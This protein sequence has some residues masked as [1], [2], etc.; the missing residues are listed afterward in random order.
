MHIES[1][2]EPVL[3]VNGSFRPRSEAKISVFDHVILYGDGVYDTMCAYN[4][5][6]FKLDEHVDRLYE[7]AHAIR[8]VVADR[9]FFC[10]IEDRRSGP[11]LFAGAVYD[12]TT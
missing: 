12:P 5:R 3:Y 9:P 1:S 11:L 7:S 6:V 4:R 8:L 2:T 10:A